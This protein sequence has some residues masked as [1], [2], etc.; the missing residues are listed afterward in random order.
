MSERADGSGSLGRRIRALRGDA[1]LAAISEVV[2]QWRESGKSQA[3]Y[4]RDVGIASVTL[5][6]WL[7]QVEA[8]K[9]S[10]VDEPVLV[11]LGAHAIASESIFEV[12]LPAG[13]R[14]RVPAGFRDGD[15]TRLLSIIS[16]S[17]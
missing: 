10:D 5:G 12:V 11:E 13:V 1:R 4:C 3:S 17:C 7:R 8:A 9:A 15:L 2:S 16:A 14:L 6:R